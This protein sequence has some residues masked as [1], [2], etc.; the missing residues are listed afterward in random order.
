MGQMSP[1]RTS[2]PHATHTGFAEQQSRLPVTKILP[3]DP[4]QLIPTAF[5]KIQSQ[6][7]AN[8]TTHLA[9][10]YVAWKTDPQAILTDAMAIPG[11]DHESMHESALKPDPLMPSKHRDGTFVS[12]YHSDSVF[13][14]GDLTF[15]NKWRPHQNF[16]GSREPNTHHSSFPDISMGKQELETLRL[17]F[18]R[19]KSHGEGY[20]AN[21]I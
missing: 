5:A 13:A 2:N 15:F 18:I 10:R 9:P 12:G 17:T 11:I 7:N 19:N 14:N 4:W 1:S 6:L 8:R 3:Q 21:M 20:S 16:P